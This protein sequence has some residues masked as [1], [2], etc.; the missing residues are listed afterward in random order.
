[1]QAGSMRFARIGTEL[2][3]ATFETREGPPLGPR[4]RTFTKLAELELFL[5]LVQLPTERIVTA[6]HAATDS[7]QT[8]SISNLVLCDHELH[9]FSVIDT[10][11]G[12]RRRDRGRA[13]RPAA[14]FFLPF[15]MLAAS[16]C[17]LAGA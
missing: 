17:S 10:P 8:I 13:R 2:Y 6:L 11:T 12:T 9:D 5:H 7:D 15:F 3:S 4:T 16:S 14:H 1:M